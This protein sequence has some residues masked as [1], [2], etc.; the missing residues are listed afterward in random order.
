MT[1]V[2]YL[3]KERNAKEQT[4]ILFVYRA[5]D[6]RI[7]RSTKELI[8]PHEWDFKAQ[9][10]KAIKNRADLAELSAYLSKAAV[11][12]NAGILRM[13]SRGDQ[14]T[15][16]EVDKLVSKHLN[17]DE[18]Q[19]Q[20]SVRSFIEN[21]IL[22][23]LYA[24]NTNMCLWL[25][26]KLE[27][28]NSSL[29][30][31]RL[32]SE[33]YYKYLNYLQR[34]GYSQ[35]SLRNNMATFKRIAKAVEKRYPHLQLGLSDMKLPQ[36]EKVY[37][38]ALSVDE[39]VQMHRYEGYDQMTRL[40]VDLFV[41]MSFT[42]LRVKDAF[43]SGDINFYGKGSYVIDTSKTGQRVVL[44]KHWV[45]EE[46]LQNNNGYPY[47]PI[48]SVQLIHYIRRGAKQAGITGSFFYQITHGG[49][50]NTV[51]KHKTDA[52]SFHTARRSFAT[53][54]HKAG[55]PIRVAM[56]FTGHKTV[57]QYLDY[58]QIDEVENAESY[59]GHKFF[60]RSNP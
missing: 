48:S 18:K 14:V 28:Y 22:P 16:D 7:V 4:L 58:I 46:I 12:V 45:V 35:N 51:K 3:L 47:P 32:N 27:E 40:A 36:G 10:P 59:A 29:T 23:G 43:K 60:Q 57:Q 30:I 42:G 53:N 17:L 39:L 8:Y 55:V 21:N 52:I 31:E 9:L 41:L 20:N 5:C 25:L 15:K 24:D 6:G 33:T 50:K 1:K 44:P 13:K 2:H 37:K 19:P 11:E 34:T 56:M 26:G 54:L 49:K 38:L